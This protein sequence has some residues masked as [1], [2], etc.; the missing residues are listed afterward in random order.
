MEYLSQKVAICSLWTACPCFSNLTYKKIVLRIFFVICLSKNCRLQFI[1]TKR[2]GQLNTGTFSQIFSEY[3]WGTLLWHSRD[4]DRENV[5]IPFVLN[6]YI[7]VKHIVWPRKSFS[8]FKTK[9][10]KKS[11]HFFAFDFGL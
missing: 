11:V 2:T 10:S 5:P 7:S 4:N 9:L 6:R 8:Q 1:Y 3:W